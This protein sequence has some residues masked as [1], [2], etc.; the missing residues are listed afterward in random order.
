MD[1]RRILIYSESEIGSA[2]AQIRLL[3]PLGQPGVALINAHTSFQSVV[4]TATA[5]SRPFD[6]IVVQRGIRK[7]CTIYPALIAVAKQ[8]RIPVIFDIDDLLF[9]VPKVHPDFP[10]YQSRIAQT[11]RA[12]LNSDVVVTS[13]EPLA[14][15]FSGFHQC[16]RVIPNEL[17]RSLWGGVGERTQLK[18]HQTPSR[19]LTIGYIGTETHRPDLLSVEDALIN[20]LQRHQG[21]ARFLSVGVPLSSRL[22]RRSDVSFVKP[23]KLIEFNYSNFVSYAADLSIDIGIAPLQDNPFNRCKSHLKCLEYAA[24]GIAGIYSDL[25]LYQ[26]AV[27]NGKTGL[28]ASTPADWEMHLDALLTSDNLRQQ[29][30]AN[31]FAELVSSW[32][33]A[34]AATQWNAVLQLADQAVT[35]DSRSS[36]SPILAVV[37]EMEDY[38]TSLQRQLKKSVR[39]QVGKILSRLAKKWAA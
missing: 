23:G 28:L 35:H 19:P 15:Q 4:R 1:R 8:Y 38:Q 20:I 34:V 27:R 21:Q 25:P 29:L 22:R 30:A 9:R 2:S 31:A 17:P 36:S 24:L 26:A 6:V 7:R 11:L 12:I 32:N 39:Y 14:E 37:E 33:S 3:G 10:I 16:V 13:T 5:T 18:L